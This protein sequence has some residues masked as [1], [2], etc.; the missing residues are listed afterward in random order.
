MDVADAPIAIDFPTLIWVVT[1]LMQALDKILEAVVGNCQETESPIPFNDFPSLGDV[2]WV[3]CYLLTD[4]VIKV[5]L[6][7]STEQFSSIIRKSE[8]RNLIHLTRSSK[9][10]LRP[11]SLSR[12]TLD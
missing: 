11:C 9:K 7:L 3:H 5:F 12:T 2:E 8:A 1:V 6:A 10:T 4:I